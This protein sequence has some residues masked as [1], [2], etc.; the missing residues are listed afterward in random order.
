MTLLAE[1]VLRTYWD[2]TV[3]VNLAHIAK[4]M[5]I[6]VALSELG[7]ACARVELP[8]Q[9]KP[10]IVI[11]R[12]QPLERQRY[13]VA[14]ALGHLALHHL[15]PGGAHTIE[16][17]DSYHCDVQ[18]RIDSEA[19][20]FALRLLMPEQALRESLHDLQLGQLEQL[21]LLFQ[22]APILIKQRMADLDL[23]WPRTLAQQLRPEVTW[24]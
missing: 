16:V 5:Q 23:D 12:S 22:V 4:A 8:P 10:R 11:D 20:D 14:H 6:T 19:N 18:L 2:Q 21:A 9:R 7:S 24:D 15:R 1:G 13:G 17:S 3:P